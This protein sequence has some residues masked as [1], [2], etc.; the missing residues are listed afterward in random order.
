MRWTLK[1]Y[2]ALVAIGAATLLLHDL[3]EVPNARHPWSWLLVLALA[4]LS[5]A[6]QHM[7]FQVARGW[8]STAGA[9]AD[10][11]PAAG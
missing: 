2:I 4:V 6:A 10:G 8:F 9:V 5:T 7:Q 3:M 1:V 11:G